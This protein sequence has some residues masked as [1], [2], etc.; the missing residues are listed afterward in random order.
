MD[1]INQLVGIMSGA[2][3]GVLAGDAL[4]D[5]GL[6]LLGNLLSGIIGGWIA[7]FALPSFAAATGTGTEALDPVSFMVIV[8]GCST[9]G[10]LLTVISGLIKGVIEKAW[11]V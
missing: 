6:G 8:A 5:Q 3:G 4:K 1:I 10:A 11:R 7:A 9:G 2:V